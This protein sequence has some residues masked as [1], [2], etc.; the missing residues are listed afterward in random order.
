MTENNQDKTIPTLGYWN[1]RGVRIKVQYL[2]Y[3]FTNIYSLNF[4]RMLNR[5][6]CY[7]HTRRLITLNEIIISEIKVKWIELN[8]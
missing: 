5:L 8:G 3:C 2:S 7:W 1:I 6:D 4:I